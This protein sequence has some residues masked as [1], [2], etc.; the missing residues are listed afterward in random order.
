VYA[1]V[2]RSVWPAAE[3]SVRAQLDYLHQQD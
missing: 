3:Q 1:D 2:D